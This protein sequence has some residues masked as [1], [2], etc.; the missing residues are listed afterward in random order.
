MERNSF[1]DCHTHTSTDTRTPTN[2]LVQGF[3]VDD[4]DL[5]EQIFFRFSLLPHRQQR[6]YPEDDALLAAIGHHRGFQ[7][8]SAFHGLFPYFLFPRFSVRQLPGTFEKKKNRQTDRVTRARSF[9]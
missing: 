9:A 2:D 6:S 5:A 8:T 1:K 3:A 7:Q 4:G